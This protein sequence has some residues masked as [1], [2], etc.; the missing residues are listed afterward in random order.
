MEFGEGKGQEKET[1]EV[2]AEEL[3]NAV[4]REGEG[5]VPCLLMGREGVLPRKE[6]KKVT[7]FTG[8]KENTSVAPLA[9]L[10]RFESLGGK[11][12]RGI[13]WHG[14]WQAQWDRAQMVMSC[15]T[16]VPVSWQV[17]WA[18]DAV[19]AQTPQ[20]KA[21][22][23]HTEATTMSTTVRAHAQ[24]TMSCPTLSSSCLPSVPPAN[25]SACQ[26]GRAARGCLRPVC[27]RRVRDIV[28]SRRC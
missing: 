3:T 10:G 23:M 28:G 5:E 14:C 11:G 26:E 24:G 19:C 18:Q 2:V 20:Q 8:R 12:R 22:G 21:Q 4:W 27:S 1:A 13:Q 17:S 9:C 6:R 15:P 25:Q 7:V 16:H